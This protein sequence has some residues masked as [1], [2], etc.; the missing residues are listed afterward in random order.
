MR[1]FLDTEYNGFGGALLSLALV[2]EDGGEEFYATI[3][4]D[5]PLDPWVERHVVPYLDMVP[6][7][8]KAPRLSRL[9]AAESLAHWL[10]H[11]EAPDIIADWPEDLS[12]FAMLWVIGPGHM[13]HAP[14]FT[15]RFVPMPGFSTAANSAVPHNALHDARSLR[16]HVMGLE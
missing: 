9:A 13:L 16:D 5:G 2:P 6:E 10:A 12:H 11:D 3:A 14:Q 1:Y 8:L 4:H 7:S 15:L